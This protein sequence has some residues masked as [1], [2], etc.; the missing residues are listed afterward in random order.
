MKRML[1]RFLGVLFAV[2]MVAPGYAS[3]TFW[4]PTPYLSEA[5]IPQGF[6]EDESPTAL[7]DLE[8]GS[9][10]F[11][12]TASS[13]SVLPPG[14]ITDSVDGDD[15]FI[16]GSGLDGHSLYATIGSNGI[17]LSF[18]SPVEAAAV[19]WTDGAGDATFEAFGPGM[20]FL[21]SIGPVAVGDGSHAGGTDE[22]S[23][24]GAQDANGIA[25]IKLSNAAGG[26]EVD[27]IQFGEA[28]PPYLEPANTIAASYGS[29][30]LKGSGLFNALTLLLI[31]VGAV[32]ALRFWRRRR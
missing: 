9:L 2:A 25:A 23:F 18:A 21:G 28:P 19:V 12:I 15:G 16:D 30:S 6:Y 11:E 26:I 7:E 14:P 3:T 27:H 31:P 20:V 22:D 8:D 29:T 5:D 24:F 17:T 10:D 13:G 4:G 1:G 32:I